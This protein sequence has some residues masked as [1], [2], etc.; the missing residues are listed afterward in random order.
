MTATDPT[1]TFAE[2]AWKR[3]FEQVVD[4]FRLGRVSALGKWRQAHSAVVHDSNTRAS[5]FGQ[6]R[7]LVWATR[8]HFVTGL[9]PLLAGTAL[10]YLWKPATLAD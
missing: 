2:I 8:T 6:K 5:A 3:L 1:R 10:C 4:R 7:P 9:R